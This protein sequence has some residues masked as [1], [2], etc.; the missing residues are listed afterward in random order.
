MAFLWVKQQRDNLQ[1]PI[2]H[3]PVYSKPFAPKET[4]EGFAIAD[5]S[6]QGSVPGGVSG[7]TNGGVVMASLSGSGSNAQSLWPSQ[8]DLSPTLQVLY[9]KWE[10]TPFDSYYDSYEQAEI[11][12]ASSQI[13]RFNDIAP[14]TSP[15]PDFG[16]S[17]GAFDSET[18]R[19][20]W[21]K[22]NESYQQSDVVWGYV[23]EQASRSIFLK[24]YVNQLAAAADSFIPCGE[25]EPSNYCYKSPLFDVT[26]NDSKLA[27]AVKTGEAVVQAVGTIPMMYLSE[28]NMDMSN[29]EEV[30]NS[31][32]RAISKFLDS[33]K[34]VASHELGAVKT[35]TTK[36]GN[37]L[38]LGVGA[39]KMLSK[40]KAIADKIAASFKK[41][42]K[43]LQEAASLSRNI[44]MGIFDGGAAAATAAVPL[45][46][47]A[48]T[49]AATFLSYVATAIDLFFGV[50]GGIMMGVEAIID[51]MMAALLH[52]G[53]VCP[54]N[55]KPITDLIP[56]PLMMALSA[57]IPLAPFLQ[58]F[59]PYVCWG[60]DSNGI[61]NV[62]L[63][64][65]PK[66]PAFMSDRTLS[67]A[68]HAAWQTGSNPAIPS[69]TSLSFILD[70]LPPGFVWL[71]QSDLAN[72]PNLNEIAQFAINAANLAKGSSINPVA[73]SGV[74]GGATLPSN[75]AVKMC[76]AN[77]TPTPN[78]KQCIKQQMPTAT[79]MPTLSPCP[80]GATD[81]GY[82][83]WKAVVDPNCTAGTILQDIFR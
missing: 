62:R 58:S 55:Y 8:F 69:P 74:T 78:G 34:S 50:F 43:E 31:R 21:D 18:T 61:A 7:S 13:S 35:S 66:V 30:R 51:P 9:G 40:L 44:I 59:D 22:D 39:R 48:A 29:F 45:T 70:P 76:E 2:K 63:R 33:F 20:P 46:A 49:P 16:S 42:L 32:K 80:A 53:G 47:G 72:K 67:L 64:I 27:Y 3:K 68:Y 73:N 56:S 10:N 82:N 54:D 6:Y 41:V 23:S 77:T 26:V 12:A 11:D 52:T 60:K 28:I 24:T 1:E 75:I 38:G 17:L 37:A 81:D 83:C 65:P 15:P 57:T 71:E 79:Q 25:G 14:A 5:T 36:V 4:K 19:I